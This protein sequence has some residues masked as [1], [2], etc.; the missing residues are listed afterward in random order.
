MNLSTVVTRPNSKGQIVIPKKFRDQL[1]IDEEVLLS[2]II[3]GN[4]VFISPLKR[5]TSTSDS[6]QI[7]QEVLKMTAGAWK[8]DDWDNTE[9]RRQK[10]ELQAAKERKT[11]W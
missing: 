5:S 10:I 2:L 11:A 4:G 6:K 3:Q 7:F 1:D 8:G 9:Q